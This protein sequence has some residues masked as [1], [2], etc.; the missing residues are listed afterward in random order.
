MNQEQKDFIEN[1]LIPFILREEGRGF[2]MGVW[3]EN[4]TPG[5][6]FIVD[7]VERN[8]PSCG[9]VCCIGGS[10]DSLMGRGLD[11]DEMSHILGIGPGAIDALFNLWE[12]D[13]DSTF[14]HKFGYYWPEEYRRNYDEA[15]TPLAKAEIA[16]ALLR[17]IVKTDGKV[18]S[19]ERAEL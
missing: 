4:V 5:G 7:S 18:M 2:G 17:E 3:L 11:C 9:Y 16:V 10:V 12:W 19:V 8:V 14:P 15:A 13:E 1:K 6:Y